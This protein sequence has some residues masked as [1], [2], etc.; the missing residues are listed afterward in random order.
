M[1]SLAFLFFFFGER[2]SSFRANVSFL[3]FKKIAP[4]S[5]FLGVFSN[6][7]FPTIACLPKMKLKR[8]SGWIEINHPADAKMFLYTY[9]EAEAMKGPSVGYRPGRCKCLHVYWILYRSI[10]EINSTCRTFDLVP[11]CMSSR[12]K[13]CHDCC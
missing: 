10:A 8:S 13:I 1:I 11:K 5:L 2:L 9:A 12:R 7:F 3:S 4:S 6:G